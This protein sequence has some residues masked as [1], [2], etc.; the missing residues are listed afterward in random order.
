MGFFCSV[1]FK[2]FPPFGSALNLAEMAVHVAAKKE[3]VVSS[4]CLCLNISFD[5]ILKKI[6]FLKVLVKPPVILKSTQICTE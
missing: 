3:V 1:L 2:P 6:D 5:R 4:Q